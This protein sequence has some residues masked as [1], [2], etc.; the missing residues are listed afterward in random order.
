MNKEIIE[1]AKNAKSPEELIA[2]A[3][4]NG[5]EMT[6]EQA[7][8]VFKSLQKSG[9]LSDDELSDAV[10]GCHL[11]TYYPSIDLKGVYNLVINCEK[12]EF[13][14]SPQGYSKSYWTCSICSA[15]LTSR[16]PTDLEECYHV[17]HNF[18]NRLGCSSCYWFKTGSCNFTEDNHW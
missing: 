12:G 6:K 4:E 17:S 9:E 10:G 15:H 8:T 13:Y 5:R 16:S 3:K 2:L 7:E 14:R 11:F 18:N 1:K